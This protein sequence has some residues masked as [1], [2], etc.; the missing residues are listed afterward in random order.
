MAT[1]KDPKSKATAT[2]KPAAAKPKDLPA[3][4]NAKGG[5]RGEGFSNTN[6]NETRI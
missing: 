3:K 1:K 4:K 6:H 5:L 2:A